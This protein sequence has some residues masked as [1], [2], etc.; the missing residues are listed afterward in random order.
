V[1]SL[2]EIA[3][4]LLV[5]VTNKHQ[6]GTEFLTHEAIIRRQPVIDQICSGLES[7]GFLDL[8]RI[9]PVTFEGV[10]TCDPGPTTADSFGDT[11]ESKATK[12]L[13]SILRGQLC[14]KIN[15]DV[16]PCVY[17]GHPQNEQQVLYI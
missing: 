13:V 2:A 3:Y 9:S 8:L 15:L 14:Y 7:L 6:I 17:V 5:Q 16:Q 10:L 11:P 12:L 1:S 4:L